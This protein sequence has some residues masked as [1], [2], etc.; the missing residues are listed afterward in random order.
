MNAT[1]LVRVGPHD[2]RV[3]VPTRVDIFSAEGQLLLGRGS[4]VYRADN[5][6]RLQDSGFKI[7]ASADGASPRPTESAFQRIG[8][9]A[10]RLT[11]MEKPLVAGQ[12]LPSFA[13]RVQALAQAVIQCCDEDA[14]A[15]LGQLSPRAADQIAGILPYL[16]TQDNEALFEMTI[17]CALRG[18]AAALTPPA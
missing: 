17:D 11:E 16:G 15:A 1:Q 9:L 13:A 10:D 4:T 7:G 5:V 2:V 3:G 6:E 8:D 12:S 14:S 18:I